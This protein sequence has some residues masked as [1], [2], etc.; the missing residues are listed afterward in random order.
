M[1][2]GKRV[3][4]SKKRRFDIFDRDN[5]TCRY[6][7]KSPPD[8][9]LVVDHIVPVAKGGGSEPANL[10]TS[11][12]D[13]NAGKGAKVLERGSNDAND[14]RRAQEYL[15]QRDT[16]L[17]ALEAIKAQNALRYTMEQVCTE[18]FGG[19]PPAGPV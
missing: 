16:A 1:A 3:P 18:A 8:V 10:V 12:S 5:F 4:L 17:I 2:A 6:C 9:K 14:R 13:C 11:C 19:P 7:G 15:E